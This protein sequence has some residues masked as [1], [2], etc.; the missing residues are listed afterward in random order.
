MDKF[1][2]AQRV[3]VRRT[4]DGVLLAPPEPGT[5]RRIK[6]RA[7]TAFIE[8]DVRVDRAGVHPFPASDPARG[9]YVIAYP[10][11]C[12]PMNAAD[13]QK[14]C[15]VPVERF[16]RDH[17]STLLYIESRYVDHAGK[18]LNDNL[19]CNQSRHPFHAHAIDDGSDGV[20]NPK[21]G[22]R[23]VDGTVLAEHDDWDC[24]DDL[25][26][27]SLIERHGSAMYPVFRLT[28]SGHAMVARLRKE[29]A[30]RVFAKTVST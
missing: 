22:T 23:L 28:D 21:Y 9:K 1:Q 2:N 12:D 26:A 24:I 29:R 3:M 8:L 25:V 27:A 10:N 16:G 20:W 11:D 19:R 6:I 5:V 17:I 4:E 18:L 14:L 13:T 30:E 15:F 7:S